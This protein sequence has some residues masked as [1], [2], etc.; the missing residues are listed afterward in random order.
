MPD[1][2]GPQVLLDRVLGVVGR[3]LAHVAH[4]VLALFRR[5]PA[6]LGGR[7]QADV[8]ALA[9][10]RKLGVRLL[11]GGEEGDETSGSNARIKTP[12]FHRW[13]HDAVL[14]QDDHFS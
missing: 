10:R 12:E 13:G 5:N 11:V 9:Q 1:L 8:G 2:D 6:L 7:G 4:A 14:R 3:R